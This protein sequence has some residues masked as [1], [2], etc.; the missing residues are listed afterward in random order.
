M[1]SDVPAVT[2]AVRILERISREW[3]DAVASGALI[4]D[5][6][7]N[8][9][10]CY[11][12]LGTLQRAGWVASRGDRTGWSLGPRLLALTGMSTEMVVDVVRQELDDLSQRLGFI[13]FAVQRHGAAEYAVLAKAEPAQGIRITA[14]VGDTFPF[15][16]PAIMR[17][18]FAWSDPAEVARQV[19][20]HGVRKFTPE[21]ITGAKALRAE[22]D[23]TR[24]RGYGVSVREYDLGQSGV[25]APV[26]D[27]HGQVSLV[28]C[29][30]AFSSELNERNVEKAGALIRDCGLRITARTGGVAP[31]V[32]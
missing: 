20:R 23:A 21:T 15:S 8:R 32:S 2:N 7:L 3:P 5:L 27:T 1:A 24:K 31:D 26:F 14:S 30:L 9:S 11:N 6:G 25:S 17:A 13:A 22:L 18:F 16:A 19:D 28:L 29:S 12:I 4:D 10:T